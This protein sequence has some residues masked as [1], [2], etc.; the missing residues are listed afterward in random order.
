VRLADGMTPGRL[1][2]PGL[3]YAAAYAS[4]FETFSRLLADGIIP[5]GVRCQVEYPTPLAVVRSWIAPGHQADLLDSYER[6]LFADLG[7]LLAAVPPDRLAVQWDVAVEFGRLEDARGP[8]GPG[9]F[10]AIVAGLARCLNCVPGGASAGLHLASAGGRESRRLTVTHR[11]STHAR[12]LPLRSPIREP[13]PV[14]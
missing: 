8:A 11:S 1:R 3:G 9:D 10:E 2:W 7:W 5:A 6:A 13:A 12:Q 14:A 4:S